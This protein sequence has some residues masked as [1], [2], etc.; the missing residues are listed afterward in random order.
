MSASSFTTAPVKAG[1]VIDPEFIEPSM[2]KPM[3]GIG[4]TSTYQLINEGAIRSALIRRRGR[5]SGKRLIDVA[6]VREYL[7]RC[8]AESMREIN[9]SNQK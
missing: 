2:M 4:R 1:G 9:V 7:A 3:F 6:S 8:V 5:V